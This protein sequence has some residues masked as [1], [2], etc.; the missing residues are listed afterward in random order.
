[1]T[2]LVPTYNDNCPYA[3][4]SPEERLSLLRRCDHVVVVSEQML[5]YCQG[6]GLTNVSRIPNGIDRDYFKV[7]EDSARRGILYVGKLN[8]HK[9]LK[10]GPV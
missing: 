9:G 10:D 6:R 8:R 3:R 4:F 7:V 1:M 2:N 5:K